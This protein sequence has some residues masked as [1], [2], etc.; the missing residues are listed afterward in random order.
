MNTASRLAV[1]TAAFVMSVGAFAQSPTQRDARNLA[2]FQRYASPPQDSVHYFRTDGF[3]YLGRNAQ[4]DD[5]IALWTGVNQAYLL[6]L[7]SPCINLE[8][9]NGIALTSTSGSINA[10]MDFVKY[11]RHRQCRIETIQ[12]VDYKAVR[13][14]MKGAQPSAGGT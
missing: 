12:K 10:R 7:E 4:G 1:A 3:Q 2:L 8:Y 11:D 6:T 5:A 13:N 9:A 14:A